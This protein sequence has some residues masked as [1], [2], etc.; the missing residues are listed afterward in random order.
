M[1]EEYGTR[2]S[3]GQQVRTL[4]LVLGLLHVLV[5]VLVLVLAECAC[6]CAFNLARNLPSLNSFQNSIGKQDL[7]G[8]TS[9][10]DNYCNLCTS[11][12][13]SWIFRLGEKS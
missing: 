10:T 5:N 8:L 4:N 13:L 1:E 6:A 11:G 12:V 3:K 9:N 2:S 7:T